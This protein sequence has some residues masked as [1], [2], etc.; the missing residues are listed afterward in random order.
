MGMTMHKIP[1][2]IICWKWL[3]TAAIFMNE[4]EIPPD[5]QHL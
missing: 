4:S 1:E 2:D 5:S 3:M